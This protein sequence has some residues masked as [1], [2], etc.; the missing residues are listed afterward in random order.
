[1]FIVV[2]GY[3]HVNTSSFHDAFNALFFQFYVI[4]KSR[5]TLFEAINCILQIYFEGTTPVWR[6][7]RKR[8]RSSLSMSL[9]LCG[10]LLAPPF[11]HTLVLTRENMW[12]A[13]CV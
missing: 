8:F 6:N 10:C 5:M 1:M 12:I 3:V 7:K 13:L 2:H 9:S 11:V 4:Q